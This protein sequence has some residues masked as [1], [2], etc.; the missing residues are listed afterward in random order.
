MSDTRSPNIEQPTHRV[1]FCGIP[2][3][4]SITGIGHIISGPMDYTFTSPVPIT[5]LPGICPQFWIE[6]DSDGVEQ[7]CTTK[8]ISTEPLIGFFAGVFTQKEAVSFE[9]VYNEQGGGHNYMPK[10]Q[11]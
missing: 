8:T 4:E 9:L 10:A 7:L 3:T 11:V 5:A 2:V 1:S 6:Q